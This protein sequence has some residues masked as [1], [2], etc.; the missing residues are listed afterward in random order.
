M[1][2]TATE[3]EQA[4]LGELLVD[5]SRFDRAAHLR[6]DDFGEPWHQ[7]IWRVALE[8][9]AEGHEPHRLA[10]AP[11][12]PRELELYT[13]KLAQ[14][15]FPVDIEQVAATIRDYAVRRAAKARL[16]EIAADLDEDFTR[17]ADEHLARLAAEVARLSRDG[18]ASAQT[19]EQV[20]EAIATGMLNPPMVY[21]TGMP[22]LDQILGG[23]L[24]A[25]KCYG[26]AAR[27]KVGKTVLLGT[28]SHNLNKAGVRHLFVALEMS[29]KE[30]VQRNMAREFRINSAAFLT[31]SDRWL[32]ERVVDYSR[33]VPACTIY[34][35]AAGASL[36]QVRAMV[37]RAIVRH[38]IKGVILD[39]WQLV[40]GRQ[41]G[42]T[43]ELHLRNV[44][45]WLADTC[46]RERLF[47]LVAAQVNQ[48][49][50]TRGGEGLKLA[51]DAYFTLHR[52]KQEPG[53]WL[54]MEESRY[55]MYGHVGSEQAPGLW[56]NPLGPW[57]EDITGAADAGAAA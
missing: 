45:Q 39:Y 5:G 13:L 18:A 43:E 1:K 54:E 19:E 48:E 3:I 12:L 57:F 11:R 23:G 15:S 49:G 50:N 17:P 21:P 22:R 56:M 53:A 16:A 33:S 29:P 41:R 37:S 20:A 8:V 4:L 47:A 10:L 55:V 32:P 40:G 38:Q 6:P 34:E 25:E 2:T 14:G 31:R 24:F 51:C 28:I 42:D 30:L 7:E 52:E 36:D 35:S 27:K 46:R 26:V 44:A 9:F